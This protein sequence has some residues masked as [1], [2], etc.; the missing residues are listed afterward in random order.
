MDYRCDPG[1]SVAAWFSYQL[2]DGRSH[3]HSAGDRHCGGA[4]PGHYWQTAVMTRT[5]SGKEYP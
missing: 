1:D 2:Y 5:A 3:S 4:G